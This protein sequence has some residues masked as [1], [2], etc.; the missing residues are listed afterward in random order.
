M[1][2][3]SRDPAS[4]AIDHMMRARTWVVV[5]ASTNPEKFGYKVYKSL[6]RAGRVA[7]PVNPR[8]AEIDGA[9]C[10]PTVAAAMAALGQTPDAAVSIVPPALTEKLVD[11]LAAGGIT[12]LWMQ[13]GADS[14]EAVRKAAA[15]GIKSVS[16]G[17]CVMV[18]LRNHGRQ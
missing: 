14:A 6:L 1:N 3:Q 18:S 9:P 8:A 12:H 13:P 7:L 16:G 10:F 17:P 11:E 5:G 4:D 15:A 2:E